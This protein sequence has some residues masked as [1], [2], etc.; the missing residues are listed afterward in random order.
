MSEKIN[1]QISPEQA[2]AYIDQLN[3]TYLVRR[4]VDKLHWTEAEAQDSV[5]Q[6]K[7]FLKLMAKYENTS[8]TPTE[9]ID[10]AWHNHILFTLKYMEDSE[11]IVGRYIHHVPVEASGDPE[12]EAQNKKKMQQQVIE[13]A[14][15]YELEFDEPYFE[16][17]L[18]L[19]SW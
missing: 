7:N 5:R 12:I 15:L 19:D 4:L 13:T 18:I 6:Y 14:V 3:L 8:L 10:E 16:K 9:K 11:H 17:P 2:C 1:T